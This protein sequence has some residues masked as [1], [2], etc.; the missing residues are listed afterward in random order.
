MGNE[1][2]TSSLQEI[3]LET[4]IV[5]AS[6]EHVNDMGSNAMDLLNDHVASSPSLDKKSNYGGEGQPENQ[7]LV[8]ATS[9]E[10]DET[11]QDLIVMDDCSEKKDSKDLNWDSDNPSH[12]YDVVALIHERTCEDENP[13]VGSPSASVGDGN[14]NRDALVKLENM[15]GILMATYTFLHFIMMIPWNHL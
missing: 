8:G 1:L 10:G 2:S 9:R 14:S 11:K 7:S 5:E 6:I 3:S 13:N 15:I 4:P 12:C